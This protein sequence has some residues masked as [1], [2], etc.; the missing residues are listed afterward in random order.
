MQLT[1]A[2][3]QAFSQANGIVGQPRSGQGSAGM[4]QNLGDEERRLRMVTTGGKPL[5]DEL[6]KRLE[7]WAG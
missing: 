7:V 5:V 2:D 4:Q 1:Q 6:I 3:S